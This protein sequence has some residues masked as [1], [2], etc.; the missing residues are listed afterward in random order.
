MFNDN[1][2]GKMKK[3][4][5]SKIIVLGSVYLIIGTIIFIIFMEGCPK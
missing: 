3:S 4:T 5:K 1:P 2:G